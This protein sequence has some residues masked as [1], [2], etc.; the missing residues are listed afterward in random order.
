MRRLR[1]RWTVVA[2]VP[3]CFLASFGLVT[4]L[5]DDDD[6]AVPAAAD[7]G[8]AA[9]GAQAGSTTGPAPGAEATTTGADPAA[10]TAQGGGQT[11]PDGGGSAANGPPA[12]PPGTIAVDYGRW[13]GMFEISNAEITPDFGIANITGEF[14]YLGGTECSQVG[15]V[16]LRG[17]FYNPAG[18]A[19][20]TGSWESIWATGEGGEVPQREPLFLELYGAVSEEPTSARIRFTRVDCL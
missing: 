19:I 10:T 14:R 13:K 18:Q 2:L 4:A 16:G 7:T 20:G 1:S 8:A 15:G 9:T 5:V 11:T 12:P 6:D 17:R 3:A